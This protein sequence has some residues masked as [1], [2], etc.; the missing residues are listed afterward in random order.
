M[1]GE[2]VEETGRREGDSVGER[3]HV[4]VVGGVADVDGVAVGCFPVDSDTGRNP[5]ACHVVSV[6]SIVIAS[7][8]PLI[9]FPLSSSQRAPPLGSASEKEGCEWRGEGG[10]SSERVVEGVAAVEEVGDSRRIPHY[11]RSGRREEGGGGNSEGE[12][13]FVACGTES[14]L[15]AG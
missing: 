3:C 15:S 9:P 10:V 12:G 8:D 7:Q 13:E 1:E 2:D 11:S 4:I 14:E 6:N 5:H